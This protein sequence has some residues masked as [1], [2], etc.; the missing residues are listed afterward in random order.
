M[1]LDTKDHAV[2]IRLNDID[3]AILEAFQ[4]ATRVHK[5]SDIARS[6]NIKP[7]QLYDYGSKGYINREAKQRIAE[8]L[9]EH[10]Y[11]SD[12]FQ[13]PAPESHTCTRATA[14]ESPAAYG[15]YA[16]ILAPCP[17]CKRETLINFR[18]LPTS[19]CAFCGNPLP[20][21]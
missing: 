15:P 8:W 19:H 4:Q 5:V 14:A 12:N 20:Q 13:P 11:L 17:T 9:Q 1:I 2:M 10:N 6:L 18:G 21:K 3:A 7:Q 16:W